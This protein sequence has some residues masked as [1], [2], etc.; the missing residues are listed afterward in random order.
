MDFARRTLAL[1]A[2]LGALASVAGLAGCSGGGGGGGGGTPGTPGTGSGT[3]VA[4]RAGGGRSFAILDD[5]SVWAWGNAPAPVDGLSAGVTCLA[6][7]G[8][9]A[10]AVV[11]GGARCWGI[12]N[13][14]QLGN[15]RG[16]SAATSWS[17]VDVQGL[18]SVTRVSAGS[19][20][21]CG[22][23]GGAAFCWGYN[24]HEELGVGLPL[25]GAAVVPVPY[26]VIGLS[27]GVTAISVGAGHICAVK[28]GGALCWGANEYGQ[29]GIGPTD[30]YFV[31]TIPTAVHG[32]GS[33][34]TDIVAGFRYT[35][36][37]AA[38]AAL[39]WGD[40]SLG[41]LGDGEFATSTW[42]PVPVSGLGSGVS[43]IAVSAD[44]AN[45][46]PSTYAA[47]SGHTCAVAGGA[48][49]CWGA[50]DHGQL[51]DASTQGRAI[52]AQ[53]SGLGSGVSSIAVGDQHACAVAS[54]HAWCWGRNALGTAPTPTSLPPSESHV[55][56]RV[57]GL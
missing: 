54:G 30:P 7:G 11:G 14:G 9:H 25:N 1:A 39:C 32:L 24:H 4:V 26:P 28:D 44:N 52:P 50:N 56:L 38:G 8:E 47:L 51:G 13:Y 40:G 12:G 17:P 10:C 19:N 35:C 20:R 3:P 23:A 43:S 42:A 6:T 16:G 34:V 48:A 49:W 57:T 37:I 53:V 22:I 36:A 18:A 46:N 55:P 45:V 27:S 41:Q 21:T 2:A 33:G 29:L 5:G 31:A 15:G